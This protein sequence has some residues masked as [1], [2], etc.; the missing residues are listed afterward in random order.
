MG[1]FSLDV[2]RFLGR[3]SPPGLFKMG[4]RILAEPGLQFVLLARVQLHFEAHGHRRLA[5]LSH[6]VN[7]RWTGGELGHNCAVGPGLV[8]KHPNGLVVGGSTVIGDR[9]TLLSG[10]VF[11]DAQPIGSRTG[12]NYPVI[13]DDCVIGAHAVILGPIHVGDGAVVGAGAVV[14]RD[15]PAGQTVV[16]VPA[17]PIRR[18]T[19]G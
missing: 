3:D 2:A 9:C 18:T 13:G 1:N 16:G 12:R 5:R 15:V 11:G 7:L 19:R 14:V 10:V 17:K 6:L 4:Y 8:V